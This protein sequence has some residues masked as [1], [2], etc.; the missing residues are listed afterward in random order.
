MNEDFDIDLFN[1]V[2]D[3]LTVRTDQGN[4]SNLDL[5]T[6]IDRPALLI[7]GYDIIIRFKD[8]TEQTFTGHAAQQVWKHLSGGQRSDE[9]ER[10]EENS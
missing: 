1:S 9:E 5:S 7:R 10:N 3:P 8:G 2:V 6:S 4:F